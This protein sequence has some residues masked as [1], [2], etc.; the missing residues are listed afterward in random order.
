MKQG[1]TQGLLALVMAGGIAGVASADGPAGD[2]GMRGA[3]FETLDSNDDGLLTAE[4]LAAAA[5]ARFAEFDANGDGTVSEAEFID[6]IRAN[7]GERAAGWF[8]RLDADG[9]GMVSRDAFEARRGD[10]GRGMSRMLSRFDTDGDG[11]LDAGEFETA[12]AEMRD[13]RTRHGGHGEGRH[14]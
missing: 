3:D 4:D 11:G 1:M 5:G 10:R 9:D 8:A 6:R 13:R 7:A 12:R 2:R 14:R